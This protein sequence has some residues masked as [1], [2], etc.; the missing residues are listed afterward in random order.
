MLK[1]VQYQSAVHWGGALLQFLLLLGILL[2]RVEL[3]DKFK[4]EL[5]SLFHQAVD[6]RPEDAVGLGADF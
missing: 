5:H 2:T 4:R 1:A 6:V 3:L